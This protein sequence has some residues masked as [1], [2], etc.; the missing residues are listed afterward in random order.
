MTPERI[1][2]IRSRP[3]PVIKE[4][5]AIAP[6]DIPWTI[7]EK[8]YANYASRFGTQQ[9]IERIAERGG[10]S[11][12]ELDDQYPQWRMDLKKPPAREGD[13]V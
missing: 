9:S 4:R 10:F 8:A 5:G 7:A 3:F 6:S 12:W 1:A 2:E 11:A 13:D